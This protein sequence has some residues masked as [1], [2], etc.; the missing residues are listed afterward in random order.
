MIKIQSAE[1]VAAIKSSAYYAPKIAVWWYIDGSIY[2]A[3]EAYDYVGDGVSEYRGNVQLDIDHIVLWDILIESKLDLQKYAGEPYENFPRGRVIFNT[4]LRKFYVITAPQ[5]YRTPTFQQA[6]KQ[7]YNLPVGTI[8]ESDSHYNLET[9]DWEHSDS[10]R[11]EA[12]E[13]MKKFMGGGV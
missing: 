5:I 6:I 8:F 1:G 9:Q 10:A 2:G 13:L 3:S 7:A 4:K 12:A 11:D